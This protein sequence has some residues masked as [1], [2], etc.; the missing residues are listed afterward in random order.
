[1]AVRCRQ[2]R[3]QSDDGFRQITVRVQEREPFRGRWRPTSI[4]P[5]IIVDLPGTGP[6]DQRHVKPPVIVLD[7]EDAIVF[8]KI[9][10][11]QKRNPF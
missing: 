8:A 10:S 9:Q 3:Y 4:M 1:M 11:P 6:A 5:V 7:A 2:W